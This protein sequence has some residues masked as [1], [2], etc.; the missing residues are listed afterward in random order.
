MSQ[1]QGH[2]CRKSSPDSYLLANGA[3]QGELATTLPCPLPSMAGRRSGPGIVRVEELS[4][5]SP[6]ALL[7]RAVPEAYLS[8]RVEL[9]LLEGVDGVVS[10][11]HEG[12][13]AGGLN[14]SDTFKAQIQC[15]EFVHFQLYPMM[16]CGVHERSCPIYPKL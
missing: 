1:T 3:E 9:A 5:S 8:S 11:S 4:K 2:E 14:I 12:R 6:D 16:N 7:G 15:L 13:K 10:P